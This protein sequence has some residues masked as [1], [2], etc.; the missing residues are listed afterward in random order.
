MRR[1]KKEDRQARYVLFNDLEIATSL[2]R[3][4]IGAAVISVKPCHRFQTKTPLAVRQKACARMVDVATHCCALG[5]A[6]P[7]GKAR[8]GMFEEYAIVFDPITD[9][10]IFGGGHPVA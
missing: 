5:D 4:V 6:G 1:F 7:G 3:T 10:F 2:Y 8:R 9:C